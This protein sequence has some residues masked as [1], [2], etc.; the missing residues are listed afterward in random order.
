MFARSVPRIINWISAGVLLL[1]AMPS[2][3]P[4]DHRFPI[5]LMIYMGAIMSTIVVLRQAKTGS[6]YRISAWSVPCFQRVVECGNP[7]AATG[8]R[9]GVHK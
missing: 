1:A 6:S 3:F 7:V 2:C 8:F 4:A 9:Q 5:E